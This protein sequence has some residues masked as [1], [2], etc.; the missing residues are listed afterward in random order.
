MN[1]LARQTTASAV[2][3]QRLSVPDLLVIDQMATTAIGSQPA[4]LP[5][6]NAWATGSATAK[7]NQSAGRSQPEAAS[8]INAATSAEPMQIT[9]ECLVGYDKRRDRNL[10]VKW[11]HDERL[12][13][14]YQWIPEL[15]KRSIAPQYRAYI[16]PI[17]TANQTATSSTSMNREPDSF[18]SNQTLE[19]GFKLVRPSKEL[20]GK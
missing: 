19:A 12:E 17:V 13:P 15:N 16:V 10:V 20:G 18:A 11:H 1:Y 9:F 7:L 2:Q 4:T 8:L 14:I 5:T 6:Q 3:V